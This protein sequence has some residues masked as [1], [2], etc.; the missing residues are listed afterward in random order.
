V[1]LN[2]LDR[3]LCWAWPP[4]GYIPGSRETVQ[5]VFVVVQ[6]AYYEENALI[7]IHAT[8]EGA[9]AEVER[10]TKEQ[11]AYKRPSSPRPGPYRVVEEVVL[12]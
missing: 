2:V 11:E 3:F 9:Q 12:P 4:A 1:K 8:L 6:I 10:L 7:S 5:Y